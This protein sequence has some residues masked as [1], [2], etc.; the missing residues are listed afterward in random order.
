MIR[1]RHRKFIATV[2]M[3]V[4]AFATFVGTATACL[5]PGPMASTAQTMPMS[6]DG[7]HDGQP[8]VNCLQFCADDTPVFS[9]LQLSPD[10]PSAIAL[11]V[12]TLSDLAVP[13][14]T[15]S[16]VA[17]VRPRGDLPVLMR[18]SRLAL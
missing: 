15:T 1:R 10:A 18:S 4:L 5:I 9:K 7:G 13:S 3:L 16:V 17:A 11:L 2:T 14:T 6:H 12:S 8:S